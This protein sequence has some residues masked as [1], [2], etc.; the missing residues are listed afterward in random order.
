MET[1][2]QALL[3]SLSRQ[4]QASS[5]LEWLA[6]ATGLGYAVLAVRRDRRAWVF[7]AVSSALLAWLAAGARLPL[8]AA[9]QAV[10]V[11]FAVYGFRTW[12]READATDAGRVRVLRWPPWR[13]AAALVAVGLGTLALA[14]LLARHA[15]AAWPTLDAAV[16]L[17]SLLATWMTARA[18][19][20]N[21]VW[22]IVVDAASLVLYAS[23]GL[24]FVALLYLVYMVIA[25]VG[26]R[27]WGRRMRAATDPAGSSGAAP[28]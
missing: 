14:P 25:V 8:Q 23:Q 6:L 26:L 19:L 5:P 18:L 2:L 13:N 17:G 12:T 16:T 1:S 10:Y 15:E 22:W 24:V 20:D 7:G 21:W 4:A 28:G 9:L 27:D 3:W 11:A